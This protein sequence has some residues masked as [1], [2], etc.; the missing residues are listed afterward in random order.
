MGRFSAAA[1]MA[2]TAVV[3]ALTELKDTE[4]RPLY[5]PSYR[6]GV[7]GTL[8]GFPMVEAE[9]MPAVAS[10]AFPMAFGNWQRGY[11]IA[12]RSGLRILRDPYTKKG[13]VQFYVHKRVGGV[14]RN[15]DAIKVLKV[16]ST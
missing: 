12:D 14:V 9:H 3:Q 11:T 6:E 5:I 10:G 7:P 13:F 16:A 1:W 8:I 15:S 4:G 2:S